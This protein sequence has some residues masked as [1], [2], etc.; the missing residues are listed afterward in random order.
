V[1]ITAAD[2]NPIP[3]LTVPNSGAAPATEIDII[4]WVGRGRCL[5]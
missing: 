2:P 3:D 1:I 4:R 5:F